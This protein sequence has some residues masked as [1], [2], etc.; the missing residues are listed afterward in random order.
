MRKHPP[1]N[2]N[3]FNTVMKNNEKISFGRDYCAAVH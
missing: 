2:R 1:T 3:L